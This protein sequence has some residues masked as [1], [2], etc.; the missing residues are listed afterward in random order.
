MGDILLDLNIVMKKI[1][2]AQ[3]SKQN[4]HKMTYL[5][6]KHTVI[7]FW[8][9]ELYCGCELYLWHVCV[10]VIW[11]SMERLHCTKLWVRP[12][13]CRLWHH[14]CFT[15]P[16]QT[17]HQRFHS[18]RFAFAMFLSIWCYVSTVL[19]APTHKLVLCVNS[20]MYP[21]AFFSAQP[22]LHCVKEIWLSPIIRV[23]PSQPLSQTLDLKISTRHLDVCKC[24]QL[25]LTDNSHQLITLSIYLCIC[26][27]GIAHCIA[28]AGTYPSIGLLGGLQPL[29]TK[30]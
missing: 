13:T 7:T 12:V 3:Q 16:I 21:A 6:Q 4:R 28:L 2:Q 9:S 18:P 5:T 26:T 19:A 24:C 22:I 30:C 25:S 29:Q 14:C 23:I 17:L 11:Y 15:E 8:V 27:V 1:M 10:C 20:W